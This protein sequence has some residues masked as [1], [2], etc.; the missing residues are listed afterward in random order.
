[1]IKLKADLKC[2]LCGRT[3]GQLEGMAGRA[4]RF[5]RF[6]PAAGMEA[7]LG[8]E[9]RKARC[10]LCGGGLFVDEVERVYFMSE[11]PLKPEKRGR[12]PKKRPAAI[13][14]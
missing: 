6:H 5:Q 2:Y 12:K 10:P 4:T 3:A 13:A 7:L 1:M 11:R 14:S 8:V 9:L